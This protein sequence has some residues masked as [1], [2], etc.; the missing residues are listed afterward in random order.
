[1]E[2]K[3]VTMG[4]EHIVALAQLEAQ[5]FALPWS[6]NSLRE[7]LYSDSACFLTALVGGEVAGYIGSLVSDGCYI[8]NVAVFPEHR[9]KG[10][11]TQLIAALEAHA[12]SRGCEFITLE[13]RV[14]NLGAIRL[15]SR[16]GFLKA[17]ER[18][19]FYVQPTENA[20][21]MTKQLV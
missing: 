9:G 10:I 11:G 6:E 19:D 4:Q 3:I 18:R 1:M 13:V 16:L 5:C 21:I 15:Y 20:L 12:R 2:V 14:S 8:T 17:G 7:E